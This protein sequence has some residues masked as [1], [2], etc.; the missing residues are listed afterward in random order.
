MTNLC[1]TGRRSDYRALREV[2][3]GV[4]VIG[5][6]GL[7]TDPAARTRITAAIAVLVDGLT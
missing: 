3:S 7:I 5:G 6:D 2:P 1:P 4:N